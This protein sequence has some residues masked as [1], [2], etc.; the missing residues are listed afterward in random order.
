MMTMSNVTI[1]ASTT[2]SIL[3]GVSIY[4]FLER[5]EKTVKDDISEL[6]SQ[7]TN[8]QT[9]I[10]RYEHILEDIASLIDSITETPVTETPVTERGTVVHF[11]EEDNIDDWCTT[12]YMS[13]L[14]INDANEIESGCP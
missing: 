9:E 3:F 2:I 14:H 7:L 10:K 1:V 4:I 5:F 11:D 12:F 8:M 6:K 13:S